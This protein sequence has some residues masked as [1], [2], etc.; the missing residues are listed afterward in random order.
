MENLVYE[1]ISKYVADYLKTSNY[2]ENAVVLDIPAGDG[3]S[4][5]IMKQKGAHVLA[6][7]LFPSFMKAEGIKTEFADMM[8]GI[9]L[10]DKTADMILSQ[11]G[12]EHIPDHM[13]LFREFNRLLKPGGLLVITV[14]NKSCLVG[15]FTSLVHEGET[16]RNMPPSEVDSIWHSEGDGNIYYGHLFTPTAHSLRTISSLNGFEIIEN[17]PCHKSR[18][19]IALLAFMGPFVYA[20]ST[21][22][23][24]RNCLKWKH[25]RP[26]LTLFWKQYKI[27]L[28]PKTLLNKHTFWVLK[29]R[30]EADD[31]RKRIASM[32]RRV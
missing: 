5:A 1:G 32:Y 26:A 18:S 19:S 16:L 7:D 2:L 9:P 23:F 29:K 17:I 15:R 28:S 12:V 27:N 6:F 25:N 14:P 20:L 11:E 31:A 4:S 21:Y 10:D 30:A 3:R 24:I 8:D 13:K 22:A